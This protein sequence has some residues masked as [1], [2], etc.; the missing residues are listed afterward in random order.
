[1]LQLA[2]FSVHE[3]AALE[4]SDDLLDLGRSPLA[5][6]PTGHPPR[7]SPATDALQRRRGPELLDVPQ[8]SR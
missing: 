1:M 4:A 7:D 6:D 5:D 8:D 3:V 2:G